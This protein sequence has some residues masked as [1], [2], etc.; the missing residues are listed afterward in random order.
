MLA[1]RSGAG[2]LKNPAETEGGLCSCAEKS[3]SEA[4]VV[5]TYGGLAHIADSVSTSLKR[6]VESFG[7][8]TRERETNMS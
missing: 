7:A 4:E 8:W 5:S 2:R 6:K 3:E 1:V